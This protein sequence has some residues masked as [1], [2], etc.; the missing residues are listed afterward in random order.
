MKNVKLFFATNRNHEG[1]YQWNPTSYGEKFSS[2]GH[3]NLRFGELVIN[4]DPSTVQKYLNENYENGRIGNGEGL[5]DYFG[6][7]SKKAKITAYRDLT[8][9]AKKEIEAD[10]N[11]SYRFFH[12][13]KRVMMNSTDILIYI[14]GY[15]VNWNEAVGSALA[16]Q[17]MLNS[18]RKKEDREIMV[19][20]FTW[21]SNGSM[22]PFTAY[23]SDRADARDSGKAVGRAMLKLKDF[24]GTLRSDAKLE[25]EK[26]CNQDIHLLCH[27]MGN[28]LLQKGLE[29]KFIGYSGG[30]VLPRLFKHI[31]LCA[32]DVKDDVLEEHNGM[33]QLHELA[34]NVTVYYNQGDMGMYTSKFTKNMSERLGQV[35]NAHPALVHNKVHQ[36]DCG[37][38]VHG[39]VEHSYYLWASVNKDIQ[40]SISGLSFDDED[41]NRKRS[42]QNREWVMF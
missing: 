13:L 38:L 11:S 10:K 21:P 31:F 19:V 1:K 28:Y 6:K 22:M 12:N 42:G 9:K 20:L 30:S 35:G 2:D 24:L 8:A 23:K 3:E 7:Q 37:P 25:K 40:Q 41:R 5:S 32:A 36:V 15:N 17:Y 27:S 26:L 4:F 39:F 29:N 34:S 14:H 33:S 18:Q 16:L